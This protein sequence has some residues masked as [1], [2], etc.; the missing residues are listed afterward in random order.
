MSAVP[1]DP[2]ATKLLA[3]RTELPRVDLLEAAI[4]EGATAGRS[5]REV[6]VQIEVLLS[7]P[8]DGYQ[9]RS[10][11]IFALLMANWTDGKRTQNLPA[12][13]DAMTREGLMICSGEIIGQVLAQTIVNAITQPTVA[14]V[15]AGQKVISDGLP[16]T[17]VR[18]NLDALEAISARIGEYV[19]NPGDPSL[20]DL[21]KWR[22]EIDSAIV[23]LEHCASL[24]AM[25]I[26]R[27]MWDAA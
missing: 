5:P 6:A 10:R 13:I 14:M 22:E 26:W 23:S 12:V 7:A 9:M 17:S 15:D 19:G 25:A 24:N 3:F 1:F 16:I 20:A 21:T 18:P 11:I 2:L 8:S 4:E 27:R